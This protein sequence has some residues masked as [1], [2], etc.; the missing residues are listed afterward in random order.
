M[1]IG[2]LFQHALLEDAPTAD[3]TSNWLLGDQLPA[4]AQVIAKSSGLFFASPVIHDCQHALP[5]IS[6][7]QMIA[8]GEPV[9]KN[10]IALE[11][12]GD[13]KE[14]LRLERTLL[15]FIQRLSG[16]TTITQAYVTAL[17]DPSI[18]VLDTRKT[19]PLLRNYEKQAVR[20]GGGYN[21]RFG[22]H[23]M[24]LVKENHLHAYKNQWPLFN[25]KLA[26]HKEK[27]PNIPIEVEIADIDLLSSLNL[28]TIDIIMFD[29]MPLSTLKKGVAILDQLPHRPLVEVSGNI[30]L[31]T[32]ST[33]RG[34]GINRISVGSLTHSV[35][36]L[37][38][39]LLVI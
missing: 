38:L 8:D 5:S 32:I 27:H 25:Q 15:N 39:S 16:I 34:S 1:P 28:E 6:I 18:Q 35:Q 13:L 21:H 23:D 12:A 29:N 24:I 9:Y 4:R 30:R 17:N 37:D 36:A 3:I 14:I 7:R 2:N 10:S 11:I 19:T 33:Y 26:Q 22:L 31:D 20:A